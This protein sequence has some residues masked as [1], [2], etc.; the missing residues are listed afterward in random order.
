VVR[1]ALFFVLV[2]SEAV[3]VI[4]LEICG[5]AVCGEFQGIVPGFGFRGWSSTF[6]VTAGGYGALCLV[7]G[8]SCVVRGA[9]FFV[10]VLSEAVLVIVLEICG[11]AVCGEFQGIVPSSEDGVQRSK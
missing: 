5:M 6:K 1:G 3:L 2:L 9:S 11:M 10:L 8:S 7:L 4:V